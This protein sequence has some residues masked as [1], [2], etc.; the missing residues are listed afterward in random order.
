[1]GVQ[2]LLAKEPPDL[3]GQEITDEQYFEFKTSI[4][5]IENKVPQTST[6]SPTWLDQAAKTWDAPNISTQLAEDNEHQIQMGKGAIFIPCMSEPT[7]EPDVTIL[8][9]R[10]KIV[11]TGK[12]GRKYSLPPDEYR[13]IIGSGDRKQK[14]EE[15]AVVTEGK[16]TTIVPTWSGLAIEIINEDNIP[17]RGEYELARIDRFEAYGRRTGRNPDLGENLKVWLLRPGVYKIIGV[18]ENYNT[19]KNF[20]TVRLLPG[21]FTRYTLVQ[22]ENTLEILGGGTVQMKAETDITSFWKYGIDVGGSVD[23]NFEK[24]RH[25][26]TIPV[27]DVN[28]SLI[29]RFRLKFK[30]EPFDWDTRF[31]LD[32]GVKIEKF[33]PSLLR[34]SPDE[35]RLRSIFTWNVLSWLGPYGRMEAITGVIPQRVRRPDLGPNDQYYFVLFDQSMNPSIA[36]TIDSIG[37]SYRTQPS[38][39]PVTFEAGVGANMNML[40]TRYFEARI[41]TGLGFTYERYWNEKT[42]GERK[43]VAIYIQADSLGGH[44][45]GLKRIIDSSN[46]TILIEQD[47]DRSDLGPEILLN[48]ILRV[49][50]VATI[51]SELK[52]FAPFNRIELPDLYWRLLVSWRVIRMVTLDYEYKYTLVQTREETL[53]QNES[54]HR[55][56]IRFSYTSR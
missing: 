35:L 6:S 42:I 33:D 29:S 25:N 30:K 27:N 41:L 28:L 20:V 13:V 21:E 47:E 50:K 17:F 12:G 39:S 3:P 24:D 26:D 45:I 55:V 49:S 15:R 38:F 54:K 22:D 18:G 46:N 43:D 10:G 48:T 11:V 5:S 9:T 32:E 16:V 51:E 56:L 19:L 53:Q 31:K 14:I 1:M 52:Y 23:F 44:Q 36:P 34:S 37:E 8:N 7:M 40:G 2:L 4:D